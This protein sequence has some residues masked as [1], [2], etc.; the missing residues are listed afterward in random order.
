MEPNYTIFAWLLFAGMRIGLCAGLIITR[1]IHRWREARRLKIE[2][3][4][5][6]FHPPDTTFT[7]KTYWPTDDSGRTL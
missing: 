6:L 1:I 5:P 2:W 7:E 3:P 4:V